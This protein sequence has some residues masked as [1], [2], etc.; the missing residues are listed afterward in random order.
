[1]TII[2]TKKAIRGPIAKNKLND[3]KSNIM[4]GGNLE[5]YLMMINQIIKRF[6]REYAMNEFYKIELLHDII[7]D[8]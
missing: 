6:Q 2:R 1:M 3:L 8:F 4:K 5:A 7:P